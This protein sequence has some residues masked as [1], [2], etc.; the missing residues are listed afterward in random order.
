MRSAHT[1]I[2]T[3]HC[4]LLSLRS[5]PC[6]GVCSDCSDP[7]SR[8]CSHCAL[9]SLPPVPAG[10]KQLP[11]VMDDWYQLVR[12]T[13]SHA[14]DRYGLPEVQTWSFEVRIS[15][16]RPHCHTCSRCLS[17]C[18]SLTVCLSRPVRLSLTVCFVHFLSHYLNPDSLSLFHCV[19]LAHLC[20]SHSP[21]CCQVWNELWGVDFPGTADKPGYMQLYNA[22]AKAVK[23]VHPSL[24]VWASSIV[25][26][27]THRL[28][29]PVG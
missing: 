16:S 19:V 4:C 27:P 9:L 14:V 5:D 21:C 18:V 8:A 26:N 15:C 20:V 13:I 12:A 22:S 28:P 11:A 2:S 17:Y 7:R 29:V 24:K 3:V 23:D 25:L 1:L 10:I 6:S